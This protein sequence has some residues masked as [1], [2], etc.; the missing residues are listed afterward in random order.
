M[1]CPIS[2]LWAFISEFVLTLAEGSEI[3]RNLLVIDLFG[4]HVSG[5]CEKTMQSCCSPL[6]A[7]RSISLWLSCYRGSRDIVQLLLTVISIRNEALWRR[8]KMCVSYR[9]SAS[10]MQSLAIHSLGSHF[11]SPFLSFD[12][13]PIWRITTMNINNTAPLG[14]ERINMT[15]KSDELTSSTYLSDAAYDH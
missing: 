4:L 1:V 3:I 15:G 14:R 10:C 12:R 7:G 2:G 8:T 9:L 6:S 13:L 5:I 11:H